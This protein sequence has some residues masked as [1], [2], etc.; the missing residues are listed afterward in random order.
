MKKETKKN[1][2]EFW[3]ALFAGAIGGSLGTYIAELFNLHWALLGLLV[4]VIFLAS[5]RLFLLL[6]EKVKR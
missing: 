3:S 1:L 5:Y 4:A 6:F 2:S